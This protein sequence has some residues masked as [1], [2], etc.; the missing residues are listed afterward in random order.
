M[1]TPIFEK[2]KRKAITR[3]V[4]IRARV[5]QQEYDQILTQAQRSGLSLSEY[6]R[7][8]SLGVELNPVLSKEDR[9]LLVGLHQKLNEYLA[10]MEKGYVHQEG[11]Q[12]VL[13]QLEKLL[14][15]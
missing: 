2:K 5:S 12:L 10:F 11:I 8:T 9:K 4:G 14:K 6:I 13:K 15:A 3:N 7:Q 1:N